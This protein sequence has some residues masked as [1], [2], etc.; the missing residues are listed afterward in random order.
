[1]KYAIYQMEVVPADPEENRRLVKEWAEEA[2][3]QEQPDTLVLPEMWNTGYA[4]DKLE[5]TADRNEEPSG[6]LLSELAKQHQVNIIGG[7]IGN[8]KEGGFYNTSLVFNRKGE[9]VYQ[10]D[11]IHLVPM[12]DEPEFLAGG[13][14]KASTFELDGIKMGL[15]ICY[16]LRFPELARKLALMDAQV[17][18]IVA[19]WPSARTDHWKYLQ[20][21]RAI[22][23][24]FFVVSSNVV[25]SHK[26]TD[27]AGNSMIIDPWGK[28]LAVGSD[29][30]TETV[31]A[32]LDFSAVEKIRKDVPVFDSRVP[33][34]YD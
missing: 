12:L 23:N 10:Y 31:T 17:L 7:S 16:D 11:K 1:M 32:V 20:L 30:L 6:S 13:R 18:H 8:K 9:R 33:E 25:G 21:A 2:V 5:E 24:Q 29:S 27:F 15:I 19:E 22:E 34:M 3:K 4:L 26:G 28:E 14:E